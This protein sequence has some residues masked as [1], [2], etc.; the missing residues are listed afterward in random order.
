MHNEQSMAT[1]EMNAGGKW[2]TLTQLELQT[3]H[4]TLK[5]S[6]TRGDHV[7]MVHVHVCTC[8][9]P[10][11]IVVATSMYHLQGHARSKI[12]CTASPDATVDGSSNRQRYNQQQKTGT[13][14]RVSELPHTHSTR[15]TGG[16]CFTTQGTRVMGVHLFTC[17]CNTHHVTRPS[18]DYTPE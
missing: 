3:Q 6:C 16:K 1:R 13:G 9:K 14:V 18:T 11:T 8:I 17:N 2:E 10:C 7:H 4:S 12:T 5:Q 15:S